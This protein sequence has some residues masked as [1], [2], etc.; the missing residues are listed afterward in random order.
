MKPCVSESKTKPVHFF[1]FILF[2]FIDAAVITNENVMLLQIST[3]TVHKATKTGWKTIKN[4]RVLVWLE[5]RII[6]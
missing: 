6:E 3:N 5:N 4:Q 2:D 1:F